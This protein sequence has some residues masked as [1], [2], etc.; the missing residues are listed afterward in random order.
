M[1]IKYVEGG[2]E[3][4]A[5]YEESGSFY[6][7]EEHGEEEQSMMIFLGQPVSVE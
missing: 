3:C 2:L 5:M 4:A 6:P 1:W 7:F